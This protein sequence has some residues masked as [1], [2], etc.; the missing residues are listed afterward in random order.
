MHEQQK[1]H[2][3]E[4]VMETQFYFPYDQNY[5]RHHVMQLLYKQN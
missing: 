3:H 1:L 5:I 4:D 2:Q